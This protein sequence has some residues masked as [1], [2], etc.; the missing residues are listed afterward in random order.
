MAFDADLLREQMKNIRFRNGRWERLENG[1]WAPWPV[2]KIDGLA[3]R[4]SSRVI[5]R[6]QANDEGTRR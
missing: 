3:A 5:A 4:E 1:Q 6:A 2:L